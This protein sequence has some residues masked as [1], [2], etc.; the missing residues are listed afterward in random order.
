[1]RKILIPFN[2]LLLVLLCIIAKPSF[3]Q[4]YMHVHQNN[5]NVLIIPI[6]EI[7]KLTFD[8]VTT[9]KQYPNIVRKLLKV[10]MYPNPVKDFVLIDYSLLERGILLIDVRNIK[11]EL[12]ESVELGYK[13]KGDYQFR[14]DTSKYMNGVYIISITQNNQLLTRKIIVTN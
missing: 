5:G 14:L 10:K 12:I 6:S 1:M 8:L 7:Q 2:T 9:A 13:N 4:N 11:G 3:G